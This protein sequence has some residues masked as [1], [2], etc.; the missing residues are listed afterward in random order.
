MPTLPGLSLLLDDEKKSPKFETTSKVEPKKSFQQWKQQ[1][2]DKFNDN[3][4]PQ[5]RKPEKKQ[6]RFE[7]DQRANCNFNENFSNQRTP[8]PVS[9]NL[10]LS[11]YEVP[12]SQA[13]SYCHS[14]HLKENHQ[15]YPHHN[16]KFT[17]HLAA[18][19]DDFEENILRARCNSKTH[20]PPA[21]VN[22][23]AYIAANEDQMATPPQFN[24]CIRS[25]S[26]KENRFST[27]I[28]PVHTEQHDYH[29][30]CGLQ[31]CQPNLNRWQM[32]DNQI[33]HQIC[34]RGMQANGCM[35]HMPIMNRQ[36]CNHAIQPNR[37][38]SEQLEHPCQQQEFL[39]GQNH[40]RGHIERHSKEQFTDDTLLSI[41]DEQQ[42]H[43]LLQQSQ[44][45][46]QQK[47]NMMQQNQIFML[48]RQVQQLLL[49]NGNGANESPSKLRQS[50]LCE[51]TTPNA[52]HNGMKIPIRSTDAVCNGGAT[53]SSI[54]VMTSFLDNI[55]DAIPNGMHKF[56]ERFKSTTKLTNEKFIENIGG[57]AEE[58]SYKD[59]MLDKINDAIKNSSAMIE[60]RTNGT[61]NEC[62]SPNGQPDINIAAQA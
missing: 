8:P 43:I 60:Y 13:E 7:T 27:A 59:S 48:Q 21:F 53:R 42:K 40:L 38:V 17:G 10:E 62:A 3:I 24:R 9:P 44:I 50:K 18:H 54:G 41:M 33:D 49:R 45:V 30:N 58:Y 11:Y 15:H 4:T 22:D 26:M 29:N 31:G 36:I 32:V 47:Q 55:N 52:L 6:V 28:L 19:S 25:E 39:V 46:M 1:H 14:Q 57:M 35:D 20:P 23:K 16:S 5:Q 34:N 2:K 37:C 56:N 12:V 51:K 61:A